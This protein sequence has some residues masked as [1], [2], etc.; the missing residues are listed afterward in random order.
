MVQNKWILFMKEFRARESNKGMSPTEMMHYGSIEYKSGKSAPKTIEGK[1]FKSMGKKLKA[2]VSKASKTVQQASDFVDKNQAM[3]DMALGAEKSAQLRK[4]IDTSKRVS[5]IA[6]DVTGSGV[7]F[8][9]FANRAKQVGKVA[10]KVYDQNRDLVDKHI[11]SDASELV[12]RVRASQNGGKFHLGKALR[13]TKN[14]IN[15]G[16]HMIA[17][18]VATFAPELE[19]ALMAATMATGG[20]VYGHG[21]CVSKGAMIGGS[22]RGPRNGG[23]IHNSAFIGNPVVNNYSP[24]VNGAMTRGKPASLSNRPESV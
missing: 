9:K 20:S 14:T 7:N 8:K 18:V 4:G 23:S 19:P 12:A 6:Q 15:K 5:A 13:K 1:G 17:P 16:A 21:K 11:G 2:N 10:T 3:V 24:F 22:F